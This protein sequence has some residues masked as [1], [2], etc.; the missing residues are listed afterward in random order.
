MSK[1]AIT[2]F[3]FSILMAGGFIPLLIFSFVFDPFDNYTIFIS[4]LFS[5]IATG[6]VAGSLSAKIIHE[7][8]KKNTDLFPTHESQKKSQQKTASF[9]TD[10]LEKA[11]KLLLLTEE[12]QQRTTETTS[13]AAKVTENSSIITEAIVKMRDSIREID[14]QANN[15][16]K[17]V[18]DS[19]NRGEKADKS[20]SDLAAHMDNILEIVDLISTVAK[21][22]NLLSLN[23]TIE[24][25][26]AGEHGRGF[27]IVAQEVKALAKQTSEATAEINKKVELVRQASQT[28]IEQI[29]ITRQG[30]QQIRDT[31]SEIKNALQQQTSAVQ[32]ISSSAEKTSSA[33]DGINV[34]VSYLLV[35]TEQV[36]RICEELFRQTES[37]NATVNQTSS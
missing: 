11:K 14:H 5:V 29:K 31:T 16:M 26:H 10:I 9:L 28:A 2:L 27:A 1:K 32:E 20:V 24:A 18:E 36:R 30:I 34:G 25:A 3:T 19:V 4:A 6:I 12:H 8:L 17:I 33:T 7:N 23:A 15:A 22:T 35:T 37:L 13:A 21:R